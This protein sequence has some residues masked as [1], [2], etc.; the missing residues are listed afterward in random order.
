MTT[1]GKGT[2][3]EAAEN[4]ASSRLGKGTSST[5]AAKS[6]KMAPRFSA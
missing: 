6:T 1:L 3:S 4:S 5:R 2:T